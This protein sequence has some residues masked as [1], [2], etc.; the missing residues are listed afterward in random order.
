MKLNNFSYGHKMVRAL[1]FALETK[2]KLPLKTNLSEEFDI[3]RFENEYSYIIIDYQKEACF[4]LSYNM[5]KDEWNTVRD[6]MINLQWLDIP[7]TMG[8]LAHRKKHTKK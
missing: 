1:C 2:T 3:L 8:T 5:S 6:I 4:T 7:N